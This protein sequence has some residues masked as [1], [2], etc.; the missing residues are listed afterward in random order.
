MEKEILKEIC[1]DLNWK[2]RI[3]AR[4]FRKQFIKAYH[5]TRINIFNKI[6]RY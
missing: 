1:K 3:L 5:R 4:V 2:E 6:I